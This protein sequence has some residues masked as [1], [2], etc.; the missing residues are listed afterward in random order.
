MRVKLNKE[1]RDGTD[2]RVA[3][4][5]NIEQSMKFRLFR[6]KAKDRREKLIFLKSI[7]NNSIEVYG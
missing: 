3:G 1:R 6:R 4:H 5:K 7:S 2:R